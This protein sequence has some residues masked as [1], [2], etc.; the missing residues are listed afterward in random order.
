MSTVATTTA[1]FEEQLSQQQQIRHRP[2]KS[3]VEE[4]FKEVTRMIPLFNRRQVQFR[5]SFYSIRNLLFILITITFVFIIYSSLSLSPFLR[6]LD[7]YSYV[8][9]LDAGVPLAL[10]FMFRNSEPRLT[11]RTVIPLY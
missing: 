1:Y 10:V 9:V 4:K 6:F 5:S 11:A 7:P 2:L 8:L 3:S